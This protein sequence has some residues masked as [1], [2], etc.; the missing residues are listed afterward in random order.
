[1]IA[2]EQPLNAIDLIRAFVTDLLLR[3]GDDAPFS[4]GDS[5]VH[6]SRLDSLE[7]VEIVAFMEEKLGVDF[8][9][10]GFERD[11]FDTIRTMA[12]LVDQGRPG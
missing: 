5:L 10:S 8:A 9:R 2:E 7:V 3:K 6:T 4:D 11:D 1:L 12:R